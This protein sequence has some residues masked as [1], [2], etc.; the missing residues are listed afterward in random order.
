MINLAD[1]PDY[2]IPATLVAVGA[3]F[4]MKKLN[5]QQS[6]MTRNTENL[7]KLI[8]DNNKD[9]SDRVSKLEDKYDECITKLANRENCP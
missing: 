3:W 6:I 7:T 5:E 2:L 1:V 4:F 9:L 8:I